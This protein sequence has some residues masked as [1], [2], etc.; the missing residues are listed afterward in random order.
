M[1]NN[2]QT[3]EQLLTQL[4]ATRASIEAGVARYAL[5]IARG[6][7]ARAEATKR[8]TSAL[9]ARY[10]TIRAKLP[11]VKMDIETGEVFLAR[12]AQGR[13]VYRV[14]VQRIALVDV[15]EVSAASEGEAVAKA[16][17]LEDVKPVRWDINTATGEV[18]CTNEA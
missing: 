6:D 16:V 10:A 1:K 9:Q 4:S 15:Y 11:D 12:D 2:T 13:E 18:I 7:A 14:R 17:A 3:T 5:E 8:Y